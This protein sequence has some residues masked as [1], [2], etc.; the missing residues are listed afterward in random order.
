[1]VDDELT[2]VFVGPPTQAEVMRSVLEGN[3][4][5][6]EIRGSGASGA[7]PVSVGALGETRVF[8]PSKDARIARELLES[9]ETELPT[10]Q[11]REPG[12]RVGTRYAFRRS[13]LRWVALVVLIIVVATIVANLDLG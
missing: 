11:V 6:A 5:R 3:G 13:V 10:R 8:V 12:D 2:E 7:Y 9:G 4:I 1:M